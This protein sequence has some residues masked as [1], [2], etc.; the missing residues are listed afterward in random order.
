MTAGKT[1]CTAKAPSSKP[2]L[3]STTARGARRHARAEYLVGGTTMKQMETLVMSNAVAKPQLGDGFDTFTDEMEGGDRVIVG[4]LIKFTNEAT[5]ITNDE[6]L[7]GD[8]DLV[9][10]NVARVVTK[11]LDKRPDREATRILSPGERWPD[12]QK[13]N[14][15][16]PRSEWREGPDGKMKGPYQAQYVVYLLN[17]ATV[18]RYSFPTSTD[19]GGIAVRDLIDRTAWM[20]QFRGQKVHAVVNLTD[21]FM[22]TKFGGR[23]RPHF[24]IK[25]WVAFGGDGGILPEAEPPALAAPTTKP[26]TEKQGAIAAKGR[27]R[28]PPVGAQTIEPPT[29]KEAM[30]DEV[31]F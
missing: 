5:W 20:R 8:L 29:N 18:D 23:Q 10:V 13:L 21:V 31:K 14:D 16:A 27:E 1:G 28:I 2:N 12:V 6:E 24:E 25:R 22:P 26:S 3:S 15:E 7:P 9:A 19:G 30:R 4:S 17:A 11:W